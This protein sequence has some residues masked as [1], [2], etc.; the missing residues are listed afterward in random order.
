MPEAPAVFIGLGSNLGDR[1]DALAR[2]RRALEGRGF[3]LLVQSALYETEP[4]GGPPQDWFLNQ[5]IGGDTE[6]S[7]EAL[8]RSCLAAEQELARVRTVRDGPRT[9]DVD[10]L[11]FG[12]EVR[13]GDELCLPHPRLHLRR[14]VLVPLV[15]VAPTA[16]HP[17]LG[18]EARELLARCPDRSEV[19]R[20]TLALHP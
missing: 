17:R 9:L 20:Y 8:L 16:W 15:E 11:L 1:E 10:L 14:F 12:S 13:E 19:R 2:G 6:L 18:L 4:V 7:P 5:V 3:R